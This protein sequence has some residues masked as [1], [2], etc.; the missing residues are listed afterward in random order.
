MEPFSPSVSRVVSS[1][2]EASHDMDASGVWSRE[3]AEVVRWQP[4]RPHPVSRAG[5]LKRHVIALTGAGIQEKSEET[6]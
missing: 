5:G 3:N 6:P 1:S 4:A 2:G